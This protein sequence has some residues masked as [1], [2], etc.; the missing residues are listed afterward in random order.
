MFKLAAA[1]LSIGAAPV[2]RARAVHT[3]NATGVSNGRATAATCTVSINTSTVTCDALPAS[4]LGRPPSL[5]VALAASIEVPVPAAASGGNGSTT[6]RTVTG[7]TV[8]GGGSCRALLIATCSDATGKTATTAYRYGL[9]WQRAEQPDGDAASAGCQLGQR[10]RY[11]YPHHPSILLPPPALVS[12]TQLSS[13]FDLRAATASGGAAGCCFAGKRDGG[14]CHHAATTAA[15]TA[16]TGLV[17]WR[18]TCNQCVRHGHVGRA[19]V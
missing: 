11:R 5:T 7:F 13:A 1:G 6:T 10:R 16:G 12:A 8:A 15:T 4:S 9:R 3:H 14:S 2:S 17:D 18:C 19:H